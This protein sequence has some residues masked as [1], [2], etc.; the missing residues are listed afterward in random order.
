MPPSRH[1]CNSRLGLGLRCAF[2][3]LLAVP[4]WG[5][6]EPAPAPTPETAP[7]PGT[8]ETVPVM[9]PG[10]R[11]SAVKQSFVEDKGA[12]V[13][14]GT[15]WVEYSGIKL[16]ADHIVF[17]HKS[18][19]VY[20]EGNIR[21]REGESELSAQAAYVD[22]PNDRGYLVDVT[23]RVS[24]KAG[25]EPVNPLALP[26][27]RSLDEGYS[28]VEKGEA[29]L[30]RARDPY[31]IY[32]DVVDD[33]Q[34]RLNIVFKAE[35]LVRESRL[36]YTATD[37]FVTTDDMADPMYG[38]KV[39][40][41]DFL[42]REIPDPTKEGRTDLRPKAVIGKGARVKIGPVTLFP[43]PTVN[44]DMTKHLGFVAVDAGNSSLWGYYGLFRYGAGLGDNHERLFD[45][46]K[47]YIDADY[48]EKRGPALG[49]EFKYET[50]KRPQQGDAAREFERGRGFVR[51]YVASEMSITSDD[52]AERGIRN[53]ERRIQP[54]IDGDHYREYDPNRLFLA[55]RLKDNAGP[56]TFESKLYEGE[57][58]GLVDL[59]H[60]QPLRYIAGLNDVELNFKYQ[61]RDDPDLELD[62]FRNNYLEN[63]QPE[64]LASVLKAGDNYST[65]LFYRVNPNE[66]DGAPPRAPFDYGTFTEYQPAL[67][68]TLLPTG[69]GGGF[70]ASAEG[71][72]GYLRKDFDRDIIDQGDLEAFRAYGKAIVERPTR[73]W[74]L[75]WRPYLGGQAAWYSQ[76]REDD[77]TVQ[78]AA[79]YG[80]D[81]S[82][83]FYGTFADAKNYEL[84]LNGFRHIIEPRIEWSAVSNTIEDPVNIYDFDTVDDV[85]GM[86]RIRFALDQ[87]FQ[88]RF[89]RKGAL[90]TR[91]FAGLRFYM[92]LLPRAADRDRLLE[93]DLFDLFHINGY[94][95]VIDAV[96]LSTDLGLNLENGGDA[97]TATLRLLLDPG[98]RWRAE[99]SERFNFTDEDRDI[100]GSD[101]FKVRVD[102][103]L[104]ERWGLSVENVE[105]RRKGLLST[106]GRSYQRIAITRR[107]GALIGTFSYRFDRNNNDSS[108]GFSLAPTLAYRNLV[109]P[110]QGLLVPEIETDGGDEAPEE[111]NFDPF[112]LLKK[113]GKKKKPPAPEPVVPTP[114]PAEPVE[115]PPPADE[116]KSGRGAPPMPAP[117]RD[118]DLDDWAAEGAPGAGARHP[119]TR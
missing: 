46:V 95:N 116:P 18:R 7:A 24:A 86:Q 39:K 83:R 56:A 58:R 2:L 51:V 29:S 100:Q 76:S 92:D 89:A 57:Y 97:E 1:T 31:G 45:P 112:D 90:R 80:L 107:Y 101:L 105:E 104:S 66:F 96:Q 54:K 3:A 30:L 16:E 36:R 44:Y 60:H 103:Q 78:G 79:L 48:R 109:V 6:E 13:L 113:H 85:V 41:L 23:V 102:F 98:G 42:L 75:N 68:G 38:L 88:T 69:I 28:A 11:W 49:A 72:A 62:Y 93:G 59:A 74:G 77:G 15:A 33:P 25:E 50:G 32:L 12:I 119:V 117:A 52:D 71:Q 118:A 17:F 43:L 21:L 106:K 70:Y 10:I 84:G 34:G 5:G 91:E 99:I 4:A 67:G 20:A 110:N 9:V 22:I 82:T 108:V 111:R 63:N 8:G 19:E 40:Q 61:Y 14:S 37:A 47:L 94:I 65:E 73:F 27:G 115:P 26:K 64:A 87:R 55:R 114:P 35:K 81:V 53:R